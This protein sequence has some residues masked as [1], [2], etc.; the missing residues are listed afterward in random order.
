MPGDSYRYVPNRCSSDFEFL[1]GTEVARTG[2]PVGVPDNST[3]FKNY[4]HTNDEIDLFTSRE[5]QDWRIQGRL[6]MDRQSVV[7][8]ERKSQMSGI[9]T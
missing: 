1:P 8:S 4:A 6:E 7:Q 5:Y 2:F 3:A 9:I